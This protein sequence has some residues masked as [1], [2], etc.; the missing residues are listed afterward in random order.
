MQVEH[1]GREEARVR[2][3]YGALLAAYSR[4]L[5]IRLNA[6]VHTVRWARSGVTVM[7][8]DETF[9]SDRCIIT[10]PVSL[11]QAGVIQF[12]PEDKT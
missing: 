5:L 2:E 6:L 4:D 3:G 1:A 8:N 11:L 12:D 9:G 10:I 7:T